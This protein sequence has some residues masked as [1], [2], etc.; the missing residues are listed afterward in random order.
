MLNEV[1]MKHN[2]FYGTHTLRRNPLTWLSL[3]RPQSSQRQSRS[4]GTLWWGTSGGWS[5]PGQRPGV[6]ACLSSSTERKT[7]HILT[8]RSFDSSV[9][10]SIAVGLYRKCG[11]SSA[12]VARQSAHPPQTVANVTCDLDIGFVHRPPPPLSCPPVAQW[13]TSPTSP[14]GPAPLPQWHIKPRIG[15]DH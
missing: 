13:T 2:E 6:W 3:W 9:G 11:I 10:V 8:Q 7:Q 14:T 5:C 12:V 1:G 15:V 4:A